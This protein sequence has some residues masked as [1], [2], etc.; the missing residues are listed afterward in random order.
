MSDAR[1]YPMDQLSLPEEISSAL[2]VKEGDYLEVSSVGGAVILKP[3]RIFPHGSP[4]AEEEYRRSEQDFA[5]GRYNTFPSV[6]SL[7]DHLG[8]PLEEVEGPSIKRIVEE[9]LSVTAG[10]TVAAVEFLEEAKRSLESKEVQPAPA[11]NS[12][13]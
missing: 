12:S 10:D 9:L 3:T 13:R 2:Q 1:I 4:E 11:W 5:E 7:A 8:L 6:E